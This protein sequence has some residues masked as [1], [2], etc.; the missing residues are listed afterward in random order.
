MAITW[1]PW[2]SHYRMGIDIQVHGTT[3]TIIVYGQNEHNYAH[4]WNSTLVLE[5][6]WR[7]SKPVRI[8]VWSGSPIVELYRATQSF[9]GRREFGAVMRSGL[10]D[11]GQQIWAYKDVTIQAPPPPRPTPPQ[12]N[13]VSY[14]G[15]NTVL[16]WTNR[17]SYSA[18]I[19]ER[20][21]DN[22]TWQQV[23]RPAGN[24]T[25]F[26]DTTVPANSRFYYR[27]AAVNAGGVSD[28]QQSQ[29]V[30][31]LPAAPSNVVAERSGSNIIVNAAAPN[32]W[33]TGY[34]VRNA[35]N[36]IVA[37]NTQLPF[38]HVNVSALQQHSYTVRARIASHHGTQYSD[39]STAS[40][41]VS[42]LAKPGV[43]VPRAPLGGVLLK[44]NVT[45]AWQHTSVDTSLQQQYQLEYRRIGGSAYT[46]NGTTAQTKTL[47]L[48]AGVYE[49]R[50][51]TKGAHNAWSDWSRHTRI[52]LI[53]EPTV[54][55][56]VPAN[57]PSATL[58]AN[59]SFGQLEGKP[60]QGFEAQLLAPGG[61]LVETKIGTGTANT[62]TF[63]TKL[64][65]NQ[66]YSLRVRVQTEGYW[67]PPRQVTFRTQFP[68]PALP[69]VTAAWDESLGG[70]NLTVTG[71]SGNPAAARNTI[72]R[73]IDGGETWQHVTE[74]ERTGVLA[75]LEAKSYGVNKYRVTSFTADG[76]LSVRI[77][78]VSADSSAVWIS[79]GPGFATIVRLPYNIQ[80]QM[81]QGRD[82]T[83]HRFAGRP[84][85]VPY[86]SHQLAHVVEV[87]GTLVLD[88]NHT[89]TKTALQQVVNAAD[90]VHLYRDP[91]GN[92]IY[93]MLSHAD[94]S[95]TSNK[96]W[97]FKLALEKTSE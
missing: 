32:D 19:V 83:S 63:N 23:G 49:W 54:D 61:T 72:E 8:E 81:R 24:A 51:R 27:I 92:H 46:D 67:S 20:S 7:G 66:T 41:T 37:T 4:A 97:N 1:G 53:S 62:V 94:I 17:G 38:T 71:S 21:T 5:R 78:D 52:E 25:S 90:P 96:L 82:R 11:N 91:D 12:F 84:Y 93:G 74:T 64:V 15:S 6:G 73:S 44:G 10:F 48:A 36:Q 2:A 45:F 85:P 34:D 70:V 40:N 26:T 59:W 30:Y 9:T 88:E 76:G 56:Q 31:S 68:T 13:A 14:Q 18:V 43:P 3:A 77:V 42:L 80:V 79:G 22:S 57:Y 95:R 29:P 89:D 16:S 65:N 69:V 47:N 58:Q 87:S 33:V 55:V 35:Q 75:D 28:Y 86:A 50:V 39:W 60:Q